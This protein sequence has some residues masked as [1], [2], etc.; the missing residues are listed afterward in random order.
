L[1]YA[2][3]GLNGCGK[4]LTL[5]HDLHGYDIIFSNF[6]FKGYKG[7]LVVNDFDTVRLFYKMQAII[8]KLTIKRILTEHI[9]I[10]L[11]IDEAGL[12]FPARSFKSLSKEEAFLF[13]QHRKMGGMDFRYTAQNAIMV[14]RILR[15]NTAIAIF[16]NHFWVFFWVVSYMGFAKKKDAFLYRTFYFRRNSFASL[17][18][19][20][21]IVESTK[22]LFTDSS[23]YPELVDFINNLVMPLGLQK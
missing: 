5:V 9:K 1:I 8:E 18:S 3:Y 21:E 19:T 6:N 20:M 13:A 10:C 23:A 14:D 12:T 16:P 4:T 17:Y 15:F 22:Y 7:Q 2:Y 11:A